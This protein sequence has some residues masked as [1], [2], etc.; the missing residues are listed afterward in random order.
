MKACFK[1][2]DY[3]G[4]IRTFSN[5]FSFAG[6]ARILLLKQYVNILIVIIKKYFTRRL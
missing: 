1:R 3:D 2:N 6:D 4:V 5:K